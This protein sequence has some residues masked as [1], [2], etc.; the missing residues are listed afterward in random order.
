MTSFPTEKPRLLTY[1]QAAKVL[2]CSDRS[3]WALVRGG[4]LRA[5]RFGGRTVRIDAHD[6]EA[7]I[8]RAKSG[9]EV[10]RAG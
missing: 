5:V 8:E 3:V 9:Q 7:F 6:L 10:K 4:Q 2:N 1:L